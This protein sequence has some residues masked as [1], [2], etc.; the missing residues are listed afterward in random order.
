M[1]KYLKNFFI[2]GKIFQVPVICV[3]IRG[4]RDRRS[5]KFPGTPILSIIHP[6]PLP[7]MNLPKAIRRMAILVSFSHVSEL[8]NMN[9][10]SNLR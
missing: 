5:E 6:L 10:K 3:Q 1:E 7:H 8:L 4:K 2:K 9:L